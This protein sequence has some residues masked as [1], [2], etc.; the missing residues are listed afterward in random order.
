MD[1]GEFWIIFQAAHLLYIIAKM[2]SNEEQT[3]LPSLARKRRGKNAY[4]WRDPW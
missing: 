4:D 2:N 3:D 1:D